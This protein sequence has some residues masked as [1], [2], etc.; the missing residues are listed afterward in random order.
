MKSYWTIRYTVPVAWKDDP[1]KTYNHN[2][3]TGI[4]ADTID[5]AMAKLRSEVPN[6]TIYGVQHQGKVKYIS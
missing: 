1:S 2:D 6:A 3:Y 5:D 4:V